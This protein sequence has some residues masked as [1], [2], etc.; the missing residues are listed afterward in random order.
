MTGQIA[1][2]LRVFLLLP[3]A[4]LLATLPF[5]DFDKTAGILTIDVNAASVAVAVAIYAVI[6]GGTFAWSR[7]VKTLGGQT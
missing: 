5:V 1:L 4:G 2:L 3:G 7:W 6:S